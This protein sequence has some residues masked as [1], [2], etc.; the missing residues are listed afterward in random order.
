MGDD[1]IT[2]DELLATQRSATGTA[3]ATIEEIPGDDTMVKV[4]PFTPNNGCACDYALDI[5]K[6]SITSVIKTDS[7]H[8]CCGNTLTVVNVIFGDEAYTNAFTQMTTKADAAINQPGPQAPFRG[9]PSLRRWSGAVPNLRFRGRTGNGTP[10]GDCVNSCEYYLYAAELAQQQGDD[11]N[12]CQSLNGY[13]VC[14]ASC[15]GRFP[16]LAHC[17][18][19]TIPII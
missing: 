8:Y 12:A 2:L 13:R 17:I 10:E 18:P 1:E 16:R 19:T 6:S 7:V 3:T 9:G 4:T 5:P 11:Y 14:V 15:T